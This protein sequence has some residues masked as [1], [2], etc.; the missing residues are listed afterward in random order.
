MQALFSLTRC[1]EIKAGN[2]FTDT[3]VIKKDDH[4]PQLLYTKLSAYLSLIPATL[5]TVGD[6]R[7]VQAYRA[8]GGQSG[9][10]CGR[11]EVYPPLLHPPTQ[12]AAAD[13]RASTTQQTQRRYRWVIG[14]KQNIY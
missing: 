3:T 11:H 5:C 7:G 8:R 2:Y 1:T 13:L 14:F 6:R 9:A 10:R 4:S 12:P